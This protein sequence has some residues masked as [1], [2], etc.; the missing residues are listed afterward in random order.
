MS[1]L[2]RPSQRQEPSPPDALLPAQQHNA[3]LKERAPGGRCW[4][5]NLCIPGRWNKG[6]GARLLAWWTDGRVS[7]AKHPNPGPG[8]PRWLVFLYS[9]GTLCP[10][11]QAGH[12]TSAGPLHPHT[13]LTVSGQAIPAARP[14]D[15]QPERLCV[16][17]L[18]QP[19]Q[20]QEPP[21]VP[22]HSSDR[23]GS[24]RQLKRACPALHGLMERPGGPGRKP[25]GRAAR[26][27]RVSEGSLFSPR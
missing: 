7:E 2:R 27:G 20:R 1:A 11:G 5:K 9:R 6:W 18:R 4:P 16:C 13:I 3:S 22:K 26:G 23:H 15:K 12:G 21:S 10:Q 17:E 24:Q 14:V 25:G 19:S 8:V